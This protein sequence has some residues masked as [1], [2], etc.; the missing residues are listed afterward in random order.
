MCP[1]SHSESTSGR[2]QPMRGLSWSDRSV[3]RQI[4]QG[5][6]VHGWREEVNR[7]IRESN[8]PR[9]L[10]LIGD[11]DPAKSMDSNGLRRLM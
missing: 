11:F 5:I 1:P 8:Q 2:S 6:A 4:D 7:L 3:I 10:G 9:R